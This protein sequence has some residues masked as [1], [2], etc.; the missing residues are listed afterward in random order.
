VP[1]L[2]WQTH[3]GLALSA[4]RQD[5]RA[6]AV[7]Y[8]KQAVNTIQGMRGRQR[9]P[10]SEMQMSFLHQRSS[11]Y[12]LLAEQLIALGRL[13]EAR[14]VFAMFKEEEY[15]EFMRCERTSSAAP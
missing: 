2:V 7:F 6:E 12:R 8:G 1:E 11:A 10:E 4:A 14:Q 13:V 15:F 9:G 5:R 3:L